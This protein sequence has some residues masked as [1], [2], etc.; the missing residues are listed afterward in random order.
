MRKAPSKAKA[1]SKASRKLPAVI[2]AAAPFLLVIE[3]AQKKQASKHHR[4]LGV[5]HWVAALRELFPIL[6]Y[7]LSW[8]EVKMCDVRSQLKNGDAGAPLSVKAALTSA[9]KIARQSGG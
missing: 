2:P 1:R 6:P 5:N 9:G 7:D 4:R 3:A 8:D